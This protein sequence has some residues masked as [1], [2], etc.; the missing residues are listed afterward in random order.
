MTALLVELLVEELPPKTLKTLGAAF[1]EGIAAGLRARGLLG[2]DAKIESYATPR[3][4][5]VTIDAVQAKAADRALAVKLMPA[6]IGFDAKGE[7]TPALLKK[8]ASVG[9]GAA[10]LARLERRADGKAETLFLATTVSGATLVEGLQN[11]LD[12]AIAK[13][14]IAKVMQYQLADGWTSVSFV[15]PAHGLAAL[16]GEAVLPVHALGLEAGRS[17]RGHRFEA[18]MPEV[19]L[20]SASSYAEQLRDEGAVIAGFAERRAEI[21]RQLAEAA[22]REDGLVPIADEALLDEVTGLVERP[23]VLVCEFEPAFL[24]VPPECLI[25]TMKANQKYFPLLDRAGRLSNRFLIVSNIAPADPR[26]VIEGNE[27]V[28]RPRLADARF[29]FD[30]T[31]RKASPSGW[32]GS[33]AWSITASSAARAIAAGGW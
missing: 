30:Q 11:A 12:E 6:A 2:D 3:R 14:P 17:T 5:A 9:A 33:T 21:A 19:V 18:A 26:R 29:F 27:R 22:A 32:A 10:D 1:S 4:L 31:A 7:P 20:R 24:E 8:L 25:L 13:L 15:R 16:Y 28:V 23:N